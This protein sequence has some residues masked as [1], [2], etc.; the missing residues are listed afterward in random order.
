MIDETLAKIEERIR[1]AG[2]LP[3]PRKAELLELFTQLRGE[4]TQLSQ[5]DREAARLIAGHSQRSAEGATSTSPDRK[6]VQDSLKSLAESVEDFEESHPR[7]VAVVDRICNTLSG[8][9]I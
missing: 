5:T 7:L 9:G 3:E 6:Q 2:S 4:V 1:A 8:M